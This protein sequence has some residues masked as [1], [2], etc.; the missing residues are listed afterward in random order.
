[1]FK[2]NKI[3]FAFDLSLYEIFATMLLNVI[4]WVHYLHKIVL[5]LIK[6]KTGKLCVKQHFSPPLPTHKTKQKANN[7]KDQYIKAGLELS[8][9]SSSL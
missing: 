9:L 3:V 6:L 2:T 1:M 4:T 7:Q 8:K 5:L